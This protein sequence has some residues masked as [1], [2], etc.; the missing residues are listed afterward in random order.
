MASG[1]QNRESCKIR[2]PSGLNVTE[3]RQRLWEYPDKDICDFLEYGWPINLESHINREGDI[4]NH[5]GAK[6]YEAEIDKYIEDEVN[7]DRIV[8]PYSTNPFGGMMVI[9]PLNSRE[10]KETTE[11]RIILDLT[12]PGRESVNVGIPKD[13]YLGEKI[14]LKYPTV[15]DFGRMVRKY[16]MGCHMFKRDLKKAYRQIPID[17][18]DIPKLAYRWKGKI[19][20]D[21]VLSMGLRSAAYI[22]QRVTESVI[23]MFRNEGYEGIVYLDDFAGVDSPSRCEEAFERLGELLEVLGLEESKGKADAPNT[24][25]MFLGILFDSET[26]SM[27]IAEDRIQEV[28]GEL[29]RWEDKTTA[30]RKEVQSL[31]GKVSFMAKCVRPG[32]VFIARM[33]ETLKSCPEKGQKELDKEFIKDVVWWKLVMPRFNGVRLIPGRWSEEDEILSVDACLTGAGGKCEDEMFHVEFPERI[34]RDTKDINQREL[35]TIMVALKL[36]GEKLQN[37]RL[38]I[39][40]DNKASVDVMKS[41]RAKN[42]YMQKCLR[43]IVF[44][45]A[46]K[47]I[48]VFPRHI[49]GVNNRDADLLSRWHLDKKN[50]KETPTYLYE[51]ENHKHRLV[52]I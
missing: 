25:M 13:E 34:L 6:S 37:K 18:R 27:C 20:M 2:V 9:S 19:Y 40:C 43:E 30:S 50:Q 33:L 49:E 5:T 46:T 15:D 41:G 22:C 12:Y 3:F 4:E 29:E 45:T 36:W 21:R 8:G 32:R 14:E 39:L 10:K 44:I 51:G 52:H 7:R 31:V 48:E 16:G 1:K 42:A 35:A 24:K 47:E 26:M 38:K 11:R 17:P 23:H 28:R